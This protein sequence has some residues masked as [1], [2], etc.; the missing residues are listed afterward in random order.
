MPSPIEV[1][2]RV[3]GV[4]YRGVLKPDGAPPPPPPPPPMRKT[5]SVWTGAN[6]PSG[7]R[8]ELQIAEAIRGL[9]PWPDADLEWYIKAGEGGSW[10]AEWDEHPLALGGPQDLINRR[11]VL[12]HLGVRVVPWVVVRGRPEWAEGE[13]NVI[14][15]CAGISGA[16]VLNLEPGPS[17]WNGPT[18]PGLIAEW[19]DRIG[20]TPEQLWLT[21]I[22]RHSAVAELGGPQAMAAWLERVGG[23]SWECYDATASDLNPD[24]ALPRVGAWDSTDNPWKRIP[25]VQRSRIGAWADSA[26]TDLALQVWHLGGD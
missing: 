11:D 4:V 21:A 1:V 15:A 24:L 2:M 26:W 25:I 23:A 12:A 10:E 22:P 16:C 3:E 5:F 9:C 13:Y 7:L 20:L 19:I 18:E 6:T 8:T 17:Y 14:R